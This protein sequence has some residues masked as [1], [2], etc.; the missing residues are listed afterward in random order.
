MF[1][2]PARDEAEL[3]PQRLELAVGAPQ[4][5]GRRQL[6]RVALKRGLQRGRDRRAAAGVREALRQP[7]DL[8]LQQPQRGL[9]MQRQGARQRLGP[10]L[11]VAVHVRARPGAER[12]LAAVDADLE[13]ALELLEHLGHGVVE[14]RLEEEQVAAHLVLHHR[15]DPADLVGLPPH[16]ERLAQLATAAL[17]GV[18]GRCAGRRGR[19]AAAPGGAG[20]RARSGAS[21]RSDARSGRARRG[22]SAGRPPGRRPRRAAGRRPPSATRAGAPRW[23]RSGAGAAR[24]RAPRRCSRA[25]AAARRPGCTARR[26]PAPARGPARRARRPRRRRRRA[27][28][29]PSRAATGRCARNPRRTARRAR[30]A[31]PRRAARSR[32]RAR[33]ARTR[34]RWR[35]STSGSGRVCHVP[36]SRR[37]AARPATAAS[38]PAVGI[39]P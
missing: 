8:A 21:P 27:A 31:G 28:R 25:A 22:A 29:R 35:R 7:V 2:Q 6:G 32:A 30:R 33:P 36:A 17:A 1:E 24:A 15:A 10:D 18:T 19:R 37:A 12:Q 26:P 5:A 39:R 38:T 20:G 3:G 14:R 9:A 4:H 13:A 34:W 23:R 16:G 11:R